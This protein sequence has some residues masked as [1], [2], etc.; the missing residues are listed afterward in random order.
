MISV[1]MGVCANLQVKTSEGQ[2]GSFGQSAAMW[3]LGTMMAI[4]IAGGVSGAHCKSC[5]SHTVSDCN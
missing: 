5:R 1:L 2:A 4:Y 3:G